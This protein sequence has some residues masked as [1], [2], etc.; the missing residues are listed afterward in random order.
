MET[1]FSYWEVTGE[2]P[3]APV[4]GACDYCQ[5]RVA[6]DAIESILTREVKPDA[7]GILHL[8][9][10]KLWKDACPACYEEIM[11]DR[12]YENYLERRAS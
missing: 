3:E 6:E 1:E 8:T 7:N 5:V 10:K 11:A 12:R 4:T 9:G 2:T